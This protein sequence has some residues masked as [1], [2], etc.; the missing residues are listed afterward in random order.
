[1]VNATRF[2]YLMTMGFMLLASM[3]LY[4]VANPDRMPTGEL[5]TSVNGVTDSLG[6]ID[7][8][9]PATGNGYLVGT[10]AIGD[11]SFT[12]LKFNTLSVEFVCTLNDGTEV[13]R[14]GSVD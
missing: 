3:V 2:R 8:L 13:V 1:M 11:S 5:D 4:A 7:T 9:A 12:V 6:V 14:Y 10:G